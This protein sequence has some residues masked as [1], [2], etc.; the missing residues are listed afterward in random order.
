MGSIAMF[1]KP[2]APAVSYQLTDA[3]IAETRE[4]YAA[5]EAT[6]PAG[7]EEVRQALAVVR[8]TRVGVEKRR[9]ELK[10]EALDYG[11]RVDAEAKRLTALI[12]SIEAPLAAKKQAVDDEKARL[13]AEAEAAKLAALEAKLQEERAAEEAR[14]KA[15]RDQEEARLAAERAAL[16]VEREQLAEER[17]QAE[18]VR[19]AEQAKEDA[20]LAV[21]REQERAEQERQAAARAAED[22]RL[23]AEREALDRERRALEEQRQAAERAE[24]ARQAAV[25]AEEDARAKVEADRVAAAEREAYIASLQPD[26][27]KLSALADAIRALPMPTVKASAAKRVLAVAT[28][29]LEEIARALTE[30]EKVA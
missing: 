3:Q 8:G 28:G 12:E 21:Q 26:V 14:L 15:I 11:R 22:A 7:Y 2:A 19:A 17:R 23:R 27:K 5:L 10:A 1:E 25:R 18:Q 29:K 6:T 4:R 16:A 9:V 30:I 24:F 20:R 13:K